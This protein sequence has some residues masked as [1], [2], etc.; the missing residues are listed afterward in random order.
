MNGSMILLLM[1]IIATTT[2][3]EYNTDSRDCKACRRLRFC[4]GFLGHPAADCEGDD[5][6]EDAEDKWDS[7]IGDRCNA[8]S[9]RQFVCTRK[10]DPCDDEGKVVPVCQESCVQAKVTC[11]NKTEAQAREPCEE[12]PKT[13]CWNGLFGKCDNKCTGLS[14]CTM[15]EGYHALSCEAEQTAKSRMEELLSTSNLKQACGELFAKNYLCHYYMKPCID[16]VAQR[17]CKSDCSHFN[18]FC[19]GLSQPKAH[20]LCSSTHTTFYCDSMA[21]FLPHTHK[22]STKTEQSAITTNNYLLMG[23]VALCLIQ[24]IVVQMMRGTNP[25]SGRLRLVSSRTQPGANVPG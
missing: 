9:Y 6:E 4:K 23:V 19:L 3:F 17:A 16:G 2:A 22:S 13:H 5:E 18:R 24:I 7:R 12:L 15:F 20:K 14:F 1:S 8:A 21:T 10:M 25:Q 11:E